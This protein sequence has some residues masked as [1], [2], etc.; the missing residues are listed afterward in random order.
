VNGNFLVDVNAQM[1]FGNVGADPELRLIEHGKHQ[2]VG[3][4]QIAG[5]QFNGFDGAGDR[6]A[7]RQFVDLLLNRG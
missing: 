4:H 2:R 5:T 1:V 6:G 3:G 7:N